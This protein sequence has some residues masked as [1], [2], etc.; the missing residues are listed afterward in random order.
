MKSI[1]GNKESF[2]SY[3][4]AFLFIL[5]MI[6]A[7]MIYDDKEIILPEVAALSVGILTFRE[8]KWLQRPFH[9]FLLPS[10]T[11]IL[12]FGINFLPI[13]L[14]LKLALVLV[15]MLIVLKIFKSQLAPALATGLLP[16]VTNAESFVFLYAIFLFV[17]LLFLSIKIFKLKPTENAVPMI[18]TSHNRWLIGLC[19]VWFAA[20][21]FSGFTHFSA[22]PP[23]IVI[24]FESLNNPTL[25]LT[26]RLKRILVMF[27]ATMA[28]CLTMHYLDNWLIIGLI[29]LIIVM[30]ILKLTDLR[31]PPA[32]AMV[33]LPMILP[34]DSIKYL[35]VA[36]LIMSIFF[37][38]SIY[39]IQK[40][41]YPKA[42]DFK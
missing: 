17:L 16:I 13:I 27:M 33:I 41:A 6:G 21:Y 18:Y 11:A 5:I 30:F 14:S 24:S 39:I 1:L 34:S 10:I 7:A 38:L 32:F 4:V 20:C 25:K 26:V 28:G 35:P 22:I 9:I 15:A 23:I 3:S 2:I 19:I 37:M 31:L 12:G 36:T 8:N 42:I 29:D 40:V